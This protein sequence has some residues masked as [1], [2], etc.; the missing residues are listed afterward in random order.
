MYEK[1]KSLNQFVAMR[2]HEQCSDCHVSQNI[3]VCIKLK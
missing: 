3:V 1:V 2:K